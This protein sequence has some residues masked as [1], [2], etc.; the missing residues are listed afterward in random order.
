MSAGASE[1]SEI[2]RLRVNCA[3]CVLLISLSRSHQSLLP[4]HQPVLRVWGSRLHG[5]RPRG[6]PPRTRSAPEHSVERIQALIGVIVERTTAAQQNM[7]S[8]EEEEP[9]ETHSVAVG[10]GSNWCPMDISIVTLLLLLL[11]EAK[12]PQKSVSFAGGP[13]V[14]AARSGDASVLGRP[15]R[16]RLRSGRVLRRKS[17]R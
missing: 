1:R 8:L 16:R 12:P 6:P 11:S 4:S 15:S 13:F 17:G 10:T 7:S 9:S 2:H 14:C 5:H 3:F